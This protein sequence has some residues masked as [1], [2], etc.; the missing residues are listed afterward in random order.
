L[1]ESVRVIGTERVVAAPPVKEQTALFT[2]V[3]T[4]APEVLMKTPLGVIT[5]TL[6]EVYVPAAAAPVLVISDESDCSRV[7]SRLAAV[8]ASKMET[9]V[10]AEFVRLTPTIGSVKLSKLTVVD[11]VAR[12]DS[13]T[14]ALPVGVQFTV[15]AFFT[16]LQE[17]SANSA[18]IARR[19]TEY[20]D[21]M[22]APRERVGGPGERSF[23]LEFPRNHC[24]PFTGQLVSAK[25]RG[26]RK[27]KR[28]SLPPPG[29]SARNRV[30]S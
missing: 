1:L 19:T 17:V 13:V 9:S 27:R 29:R 16:P 2:H 20:L 26:V 8:A 4:V 14:L 7:I 21:F 23:W 22:K 15:Q 11:G 28:R 6:I 10:P 18:A 24:S 5:V 3:P 12:I 30:V 25:F